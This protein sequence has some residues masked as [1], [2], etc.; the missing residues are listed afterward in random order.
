MGNTAACAARSAEIYAFLQEKLEGNTQVTLGVRHP[1]SFCFRVSVPTK[2][3]EHEAWNYDLDCCETKEVEFDE[4]SISVPPETMGNR[5]GEPVRT[6]ETALFLGNKLVYVS[7]IGY[8]D[9]IRFSDMESP[10]E[11]ILRVAN[12]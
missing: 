1:N 10:L 12:L 7:S 2:K 3:A 8:E 11:G 4:I 6:F 5:E 9:V